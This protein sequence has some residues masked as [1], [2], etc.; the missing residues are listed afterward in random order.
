MY[1]D[2]MFTDLKTMPIPKDQNI[3]SATLQFMMNFRHILQELINIYLV[4]LRMCSTVII[5]ESGR[6]FFDT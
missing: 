4:N 6:Y 5:S 2:S 1:S 3:P